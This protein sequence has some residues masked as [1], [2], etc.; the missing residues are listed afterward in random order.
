[1]KTYVIPPTIKEREKVIGG[2]LDMTQ[3]GWIMGGAV[4]GVLVFLLLLPIS[5]VL[6]GIF[7]CIFGLSGVPFAFIKIKG[8]SI[9]KYIKYKKQFDKKHKKLP[10]KRKLN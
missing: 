9:L 3:A 8:Y 5:K 7:G 6:G 2:I 1:M 4:V 10:N